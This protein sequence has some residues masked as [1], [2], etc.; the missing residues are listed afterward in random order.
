MAHTISHPS[1]HFISISCNIQ[2]DQDEALQQTRREKHRM[3]VEMDKM[4]NTIMER[5]ESIRLLT[6]ANKNLSAHFTRERQ[7][8]L[9]E[10]PRQ[11]WSLATPLVRHNFEIEGGVRFCHL[12]RSPLLYIIFSS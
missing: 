9:W 6:E 11:D 10:S 1:A 2:G 5:D 3:Q 8:G 4:R 7:G 12:S